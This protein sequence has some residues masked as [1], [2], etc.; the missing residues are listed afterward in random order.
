MS[1]KISIPEKSHGDRKGEM[2]HPIHDMTD[3]RDVEEPNFYCMIISLIVKKYLY[4][5]NALVF[6][7][8]ENWWIF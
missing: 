4:K 6:Q 5:L 7:I 1:D 2:S 3:K 8:I